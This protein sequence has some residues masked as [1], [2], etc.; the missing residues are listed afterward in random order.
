MGL[1]KAA[2]I[3]GGGAYAINKIS[4]K[5]EQKKQNRMQFEQNMQSR[6]FRDE[7]PYSDYPNEKKSPNENGYYYQ[8]NSQQ[9]YQQTPTHPY[10]LEFTDR[11]SPHQQQQSRPMSMRLNNNYNEQV[12]QFAGGNN[13]YSYTQGPPP[14]QYHQVPSVQR[15]HGFVE[16]D[17]LS[18]SPAPSEHLSSWD[19]KSR[20][21]SREGGQT[22]L[23]TLA[24]QVSGLGS[25]RKGASSPKEYLEKHLSR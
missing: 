5:R 17:E 14:P 2:I 19:R 1:I 16:P 23:N 20:R 10:A 15:T 24:Q 25:D 9:Q 21:E 6:D 8:H 12:P 13:D 7:P 22:L 11:R 3:V 4:K 18:P